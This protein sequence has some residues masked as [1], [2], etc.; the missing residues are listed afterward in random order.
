MLFV[1]EEEQSTDSCNH[2]DKPW[3]LYWKNGV[4]K[5]SNKDYLLRNLFSYET[6][7]I[8]KATEIESTRLVIAKE[9]WKWLGYGRRGL[10][11]KGFY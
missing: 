5:E 3:K 8:G 6:S 7:R 1:N 4:T 9:G 11:W 2:I 10:L